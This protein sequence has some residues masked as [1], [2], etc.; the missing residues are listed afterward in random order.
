[1]SFKHLITNLVFPPK[2]SN[3]NSFLDIDIKSKV[4][5]TLCPACRV[6][7]ESEKERECGFCGLAMKFCRCMPRNLERA[8][9]SCLLKLLSYRPQDESFPIRQFLY[10]VKRRDDRIYFDFVAEQMRELLIVEMRS[11][12]LLP[13]DCIITYLPR[14]SKNL[15]EHGFD[16]GKSLS[17]SLS[18]ITGIEFVECFKRKLFAEEQKNLN[19][20]ERR[21]NMRSAYEILDVENIIKDKTVIL[22]D[23]IVTTGSSMAA[24]TRLLFSRGAYDVMGL[25]IGLTEKEKNIYKNKRRN[26]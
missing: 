24:C 10:S 22:V 3:C 16:Q 6:Q 13:D 23:D 19:Q 9:C 18:N 5:D 20:Y 12:S 4:T 1:M 26:D 8:Q 2:C 7:Y 14:A 15:A 25:C 21:L 17:K 11:R